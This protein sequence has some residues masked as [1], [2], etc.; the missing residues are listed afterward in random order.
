MPG[1]PTDLMRNLAVPAIAAPMFL[2][3]GPDLALAACRAGV[4]GTFPAL[5]ARPAEVL[6]DWL[7]QMQAGVDPA[8]DAAWGVNLV[9]HR[10]NESRLADDLDLIEQYRVPL[11]ITSVG[12]PDA[13]APRIHAYGGRVLH[14]VTT[15]R[16]A[17]RA[18]AAG[19]DGLILVCAGAGGN[20][21]L[22]NPFAFLAEVRQFWPGLLV[23]A[24]GIMSGRDIRA[25]QVMGADLVYL[26][27]RFLAAG[28]SLAEAPYK[29]MV[30]AAEAADIL[31]T[32]AFSGLRANILIPSIRRA[33][34][35]PDNLPAVDAV[36]MARHLD[37]ARRRWRDI[38][39][40]GQGVGQVAAIA[41][42]ADIV[43]DL[44]A[45]YRAAGPTA[46]GV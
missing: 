19:V 46:A 10:S 44:V 13:I 17:K 25:A 42:V 37:P 6:G 32:D 20:A 30:V 36:D 11:V 23:L 2:V 18:A 7:H 29:A 27:T 26:G 40:A 24:G 15:V 34:L 38:W 1:Q 16:H 35:D 21:G 22:L 3:S 39:G 41:P 8:R 43:A 4:I 12:A 9:V 14:D 45:E 33:G 28:E 31:H 5:N